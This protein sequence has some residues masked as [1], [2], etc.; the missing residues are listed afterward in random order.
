[1][2]A[3]DYRGNNWQSSYGASGR[4]LSLPCSDPSC[5]WEVTI[6][7]DVLGQWYGKHEHSDRGAWGHRPSASTI[8]T[9]RHTH[10]QDA[11]AEIIDRGIV[12]TTRA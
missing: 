6:Q 12:D 7:R 2:S 1:M 5:L 3:E 8:T 10:W 4:V 11:A 9:R